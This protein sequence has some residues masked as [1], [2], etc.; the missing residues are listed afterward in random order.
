MDLNCKLLLVFDFNAQ[1]KWETS[2]LPFRGLL[3]RQ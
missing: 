3:S 1:R 2:K